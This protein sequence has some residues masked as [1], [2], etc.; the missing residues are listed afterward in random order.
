MCV[1]DEHADMLELG[2]S[3]LVI[4]SSPRYVSREIYENL[5]MIDT[6]FVY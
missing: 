2:D 1:G 4:C 5:S 3:E 6:R